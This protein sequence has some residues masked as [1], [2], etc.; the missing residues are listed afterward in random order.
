MNDLQIFESEE[1]GQVR[2]RE[3]FRLL[4]TNT[5]GSDDASAIQTK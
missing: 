1:F 4:C 2:S 3:T 5:E